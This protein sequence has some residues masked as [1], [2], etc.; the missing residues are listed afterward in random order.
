MGINYR[1]N[2]DRALVDNSI[3]YN[4]AY[5]PED[6]SGSGVVDEPVTVSE[7]KN[8]LRLQGF[9]PCVSNS[10]TAQVPL[11]LT[12]L[13]GATS[14]LDPLLQQDNVVITG[15][16]REGTGYSQ[17]SGSPTTRG[18]VFNPTAGTVTFLQQGN[19]GGETIDIQ[20]GIQQVEPV[21]GDDF[22]FDDDLIADMIIS[23]R[24]RVEIDTDCSLVSKTL[25]ARIT[26]LCGGVSLRGG[27]ITGVISGV[28]CENTA[29]NVD[30]L[31]TIGSSKFPDL[32]SPLQKDMILTYEAGYTN[33]NIP[34]GLKLAI[35]EQVCYDYEHRGEELNEEGICQKAAKHA[36]KY[37][38]GSMFG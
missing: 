27:P 36:S 5:Q 6:I 30:D 18:F 20:Y 14:V 37:R 15:V 34:R 7:M 21:S 28:D 1:R 31:K 8:Y 23:A 10:V 4:L 25:E 19:V 26:N 29:I 3:A 38:R 16:Q 17:V 24:E 35:M 11:S 32:V 2:E 13:E 9:S 12:L 33:S 22:D